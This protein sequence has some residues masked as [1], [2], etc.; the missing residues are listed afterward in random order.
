[1]S[2]WVSGH[3]IY[4]FGLLFPTPP[5]SCQYVLSPQ[6]QPFILPRTLALDRYL[7]HRPPAFPTGAVN[8]MEIWPSGAAPLSVSGIVQLHVLQQATFVGVKVAV[9]D[10]L[11]MEVQAGSSSMSFVIAVYYSVRYKMVFFFFTFTNYPRERIS[12]LHFLIQSLR[13]STLTTL[14]RRPRT[15]AL[16]QL[17]HAGR[18]HSRA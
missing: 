3:P 7:F 18:L 11:C 4:P 5:G 6:P 14:F 13:W 9:V 12:I 16:A 1:M 2:T 15:L 17:P 8:C 10:Y